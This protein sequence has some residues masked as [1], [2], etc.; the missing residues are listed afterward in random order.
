MLNRLVIASA[1]AAVS[2]SVAAGS[3]VAAPAARPCAGTFAVPDVSASLGSSPNAHRWAALALAEANRG[4]GTR[5]RIVRLSGANTDASA[6][7]IGRRI[8]ANP[9]VIG[10]VGFQTSRTTAAGGPVLDRAGIGYVSQSATRTSLADGSLR[11]FHRVVAAD[12]QQGPAIAKTIA[13]ELM[14]TSV[15]VIAQRD[16]YSSDLATDIARALR[17]RNIPTTTRVTALDQASYAGV[18]AGLPAGVDV[19][20]LPFISLA[21]ATRFAEEARAMG[22]TAAFIGGD[23]LFSNDNPIVGSYVMYTAGELSATITGRRVAA[24]YRARYGS[25]NPAYVSAYI[26]ASALVQAARR[27]CAADGSAT[28]AGVLRELGSVRIPRSLFG[29]PVSFTEDGNLRSATNYLW[30]VGSSGLDYVKEAPAVSSRTPDE[31]LADRSADGLE[32]MTA[33]SDLL[34]AQDR[35]ALR[36]VLSPAF[37]IQRTDGSWSDRRSFLARL[38]ELQSFSFAGVAERR[39]NDQIVV[40][41][42]A[43]STLKVAGALYRGDPAPLLGAWRWQDGGWRLVAQGNFNLPR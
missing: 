1:F 5:F 19:I 39:S 23:A 42:S 29:R 2:L 38:P 27:A 9:D 43:T 11:G 25:Y 36:R 28:R 13:D 4:Y 24:A 16:P 21:D 41:M 31:V 15:A 33:Y 17:S 18:I 7:A 20:A 32:L 12:D 26:A 30:R 37:M 10:V 6:R 22:V 34:V 3:A 8:V 35:A 14:G 40:R